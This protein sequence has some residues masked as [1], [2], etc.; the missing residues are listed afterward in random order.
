MSQASIGITSRHW[1]ARMRRKVASEY[2]LQEH[3]VSLSPA[4][5]A[6]LAVIGGGPSFRKDGPFPIYERTDLDAFA[7]VRLGPLRTSTSDQL[8]AA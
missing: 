3:G 8:Q 5:L 7:T 4:T 2:L 6:K 1:P